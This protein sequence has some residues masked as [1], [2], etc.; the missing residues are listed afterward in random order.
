MQPFRSACV[1]MGRT[2]RRAFE[3]NFH[4]TGTRSNVPAR[5]VKAVYKLTGTFP[6]CMML[7]LVTGSSVLV[8]AGAHPDV[9]HGAE[10]CVQ[11]L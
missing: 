1:G 2:R 8:S 11:I 5:V 4:L 6:L 7:L 3:W 10:F 9:W